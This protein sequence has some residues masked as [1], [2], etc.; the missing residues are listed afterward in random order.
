MRIYYYVSTIASEKKIYSGVLPVKK[1]YF[2]CTVLISANRCNLNPV[3]YIS[4]IEI[5]EKFLDLK[6]NNLYINEI[7]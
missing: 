6:S 7:F 2:L 1:L 5:A 4:N 3:C